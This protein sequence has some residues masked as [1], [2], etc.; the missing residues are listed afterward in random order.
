MEPMAG[1]ALPVRLAY[2]TQVLDSHPVL[3]SPSIANQLNFAGK[4]EWLQPLFSPLLPPSLRWNLLEASLEVKCEELISETGGGIGRR[5]N[6]FY[7]KLKGTINHDQNQVASPHSPTTSGSR[8]TLE[9]GA[10][11]PSSG[12][13]RQ[14]ARTLQ[15]GQ[16]QRSPRCQ[17]V[18][19][20]KNHRE[21]SERE[22]RRPGL[23]KVSWLYLVDPEAPQSEF[24]MFSL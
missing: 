22:Q 11:K 9:Y 12:N 16:A 3:S 23:S 20:H 14:T 15:I 13:G 17:F 5:L 18:Q 19:R 10:C 8:S 2:S 1:I 6:W 4:F 24:R 7:Q 21:I